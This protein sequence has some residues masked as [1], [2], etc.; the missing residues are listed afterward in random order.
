[1]KKETLQIRKDKAQYWYKHIESWRESNL[2]QVDYCC[3]NDLPIKN[4]G[5]WKKRSG[6]RTPEKQIFYPLIASEMKQIPNP[7]CGLVAVVFLKNQ[8]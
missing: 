3:I 4:F 5:Y 1:M 8:H 2:S 7:I 6:Q